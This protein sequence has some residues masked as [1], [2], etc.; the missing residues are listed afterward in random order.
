MVTSPHDVIEPPVDLL[1]LRDTI[2]T[3]YGHDTGMG[4]LN[5]G[6]MQDNQQRDRDRLE[7]LYWVAFAA[8]RARFDPAT[9]TRTS[10]PSTGLT[11]VK[12]KDGKG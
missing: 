5:G 8:Q 7:S 3:C 4:V 2:A 6:A 11:R 10:R 1:R 9:G 12:T